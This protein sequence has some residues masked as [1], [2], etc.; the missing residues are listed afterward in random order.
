MKILFVTST[1]IGDAV[2]STGLLAHL[3]SQFPEAQITVASGAL[4]APLF[5]RAPGVIRVIRLTKKAFAGHWLGLWSEVART[6]WDLVV[7]LRGSALAWTLLTK[8]RRV[9]RR[10]DNPLHRVE[11]LAGLFGLSDPPSPCLW[12]SATDVIEAER[13]IASGAP[14][15]ALGPTANWAAKIWPAASF[16]ALL[17]RLTGSNGILAGARVAIF[18]GP[19]ERD[20]AQPVLDAIPK[21]RLIDLVGSL[22]LPIVAACLRRCAIFIGND[23]GLMHM[24][25]A[26][27]TPTLGLFGPSQTT[28]YAPWGTHCSA[29]ETTIPYEDLVGNPG[30]DHMATTC[31]MTSLSTQT[32]I[33]EAEALWRRTSGEAA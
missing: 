15:L 16:V 29:V 24:S 5:E 10:G 4:P 21:D 13:C 31:L 22:E 26:V 25:A 19:G 11:A 27:G 12:S 17:E 1:R 8:K 6:A 7:D 30:F 33:A 2:L 18:G 3:A 32:V 28:H 20:L 23:S 9:F 14:V